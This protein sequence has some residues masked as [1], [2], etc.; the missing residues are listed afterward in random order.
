MEKFLI[1]LRPKNI[2]R[3]VVQEDFSK[4]VSQNI[5]FYVLARVIIDGNIVTLIPN[6]KPISFSSVAIAAR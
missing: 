1:V 5:Q 6:Q 4:L 3:W 2:K